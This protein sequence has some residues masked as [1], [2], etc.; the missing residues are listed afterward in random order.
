MYMFLNKINIFFRNKYNAKVIENME[1][2]V[3]LSIMNIP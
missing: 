1:L 2:L 3:L